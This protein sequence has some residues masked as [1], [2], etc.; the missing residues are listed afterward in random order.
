MSEIEYKNIETNG[1]SL[2]L[3]IQGEGPLVIYCHGWPESWY[4]YRYQLPIVASAGYKAV[5]Y[6]V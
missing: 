1:I 4:S 2:R 3:A 5:A 6:D